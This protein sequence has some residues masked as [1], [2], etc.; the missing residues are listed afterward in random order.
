MS[1]QTTSPYSIHWILARQVLSPSPKSSLT[2][3]T[4]LVGVANCKP[5]PSLKPLLKRAQHFLQQQI[6]D[7]P[8]YIRHPETQV[9]MRVEGGEVPP[10]LTR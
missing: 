7:H 4:A 10:E 5:R 1:K 3:D 2:C 6:S 9:W 8:V